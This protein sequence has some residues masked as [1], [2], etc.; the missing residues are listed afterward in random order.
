L[1]FSWFCS[2]YMMNKSSPFSCWDYF[3][4]HLFTECFLFQVD[5][6]VVFFCVRILNLDFVFKMKKCLVKSFYFE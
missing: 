1:M 3:F 5:L 4:Y 2:L 6:I